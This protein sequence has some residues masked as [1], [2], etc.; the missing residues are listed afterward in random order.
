MTDLHKCT[1]N[2]IT[3]FNVTVNLALLDPSLTCAKSGLKGS[4]Q[5]SI[6][7]WCSSFSIY[8]WVLIGDNVLKGSQLLCCY[9]N[10]WY[11]A[12]ITD[13]IKSMLYVLYAYIGGETRDRKQSKQTTNHLPKSITGFYSSILFCDSIWKARKHP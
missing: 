9:K 7:E 5:L 2:A 10:V 6:C 13:W 4:G 1:Y 11:H 3:Y 12:S 8:E